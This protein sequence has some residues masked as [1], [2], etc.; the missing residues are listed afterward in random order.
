MF[1]RLDEIKQEEKRI[2]AIRIVGERID[3][4]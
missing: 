3:E 4:R 1:F 2:F